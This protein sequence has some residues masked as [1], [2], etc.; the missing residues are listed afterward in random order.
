MEI[1]K[2]ISASS[3]KLYTHNLKKLN[4]DQEIK[5]LNFLK[6]KEHILEMLESKKPNTKRTY[7]ISIIS[8]VKNSENKAI[9]KLYEYYY[10][11]LEQLNKELI[12]NTKKTDKEVD[13]WI[14]KED[15]KEI[16]DKCDAILVDIKGKRKIDDNQY[17]KLLDCVILS[18]YT[19]TVPR[20]SLDYI[21][22]VVDKPEENQTT[23]YYYQS[24]FYFN[25]FKTQKTYQQQIIDVPPSLDNIIKLYLK[26]KKG[27][28]PHF[29]VNVKGVQL[30]TSTDMTNRLNKIFDSKVSSSMLRK[31]YLTSKY[32]NVIEELQSDTID[33]GTSVGTA[34]N[35]YIKKD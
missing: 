32:G 16:T 20:R 5:N 12:D 18:L 26:H 9:K 29:L 17:S 14:T 31:Q 11:M 15:L 24:K 6:N 8:A 33:M 30:K 22:M 25:R 7:L 13:N 2:D 28:T 4:Q 19:K 34:M 35:N 10:P 23:N 27:D 21:E 3:K 1:F